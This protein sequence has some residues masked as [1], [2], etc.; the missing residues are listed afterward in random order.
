MYILS[1]GDHQSASLPNE[2]MKSVGK[3]LLFTF[4]LC[5][6]GCS[7]DGGDRPRQAKPLLLQLALLPSGALLEYFDD[8]ILLQ[9]LSMKCTDPEHNTEYSTPSFHKPPGGK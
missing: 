8:S 3:H 6:A 5:A 9:E 7:V 4:T 2:C 1:G